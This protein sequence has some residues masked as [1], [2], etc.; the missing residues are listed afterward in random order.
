MTSVLQLV[1]TLVSGFSMSGM[2]DS[3]GEMVP[4]GFP[5]G[6]MEM[7]QGLPESGFA[8][9]AM[10]LFSALFMMGIFSGF[11]ALGYQPL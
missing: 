10:Q 2:L 3:L 9:V 5:E 4:G 6:S 11:G 1:W 8:L 7:L